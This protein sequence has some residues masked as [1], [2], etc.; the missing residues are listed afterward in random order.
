MKT[1]IHP[2]WYEECKV[3]CACGNSFVIGATVPQ[4]Q[5]EVCYNCHPFYTGQMKYVDTAGRVDAFMAKTKK[6]QTKVVSKSEKRKL[7]KERKIQKEL[8]RP[9]TLEDLRKLTKKS[10]KNK[11]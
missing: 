3:T 11:N 1:A 4:I 9:E 5:V 6:A 2:K 10:K 7:K 8:D